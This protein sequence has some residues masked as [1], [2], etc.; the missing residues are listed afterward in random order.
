MNSLEIPGVDGLAALDRHDG[1]QCFR[2]RLR[3]RRGVPP[4]RTR[5]DM[6][7]T[8]WL[9]SIWAFFQA[10]I[11]FPGGKAPREG[12]SVG[13]G[14]HARRRGHVGAR[15]RQHHPGKPGPRLPRL[16]RYAVASA[17]AWSTRRASTL[18]VS[19]TRSGAVARPGSST[20]DSPTAQCHSSSSSAMPCIRTPTSGSSTWW[21]VH[22][23][24][25][26]VC[27]MFFRDPPK[28]WWPAD[29]DP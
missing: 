8:F 4:R 15:I 10:G 11:A 9:L 24:G 2:V 22:A 16:R 19:G 26:A 13:Q 23:G 27:G 28:N 17:Q 18:W 3:L 7:Q 6:G 12:H 14:R 20:A 25:L 5:L 29:V 1:G 21:R